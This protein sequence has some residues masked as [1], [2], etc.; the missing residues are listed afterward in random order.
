MADNTQTQKTTW[1]EDVGNA[2]VSGVNT[3][4][5]LADSMLDTVAP[6]KSQMDGLISDF[7]NSNML[8]NLLTSNAPV[9]NVKMALEELCNMILK[10]DEF[11][12]DGWEN[13]GF[14]GNC[15]ESPSKIA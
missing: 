12:G 14:L 3:W 1:Y 5:G 15:W 6:G 7:S 2:I 10:W 11:W 9:L 4:D 8:T 13:S